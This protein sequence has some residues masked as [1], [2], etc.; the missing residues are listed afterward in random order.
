LARAFAANLDESQLP[1]SRTNHRYSLVLSAPSRDSEKDFR[2]GARE[3]LA[4]W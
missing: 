2:C 1:K 3:R 4:T